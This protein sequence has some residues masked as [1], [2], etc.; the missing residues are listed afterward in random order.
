MKTPKYTISYH[1]EDDDDSAAP[2]YVP[3]PLLRSNGKNSADAHVLTRVIPPSSREI[4]PEVEFIRH[5]LAMLTYYRL[6]YQGG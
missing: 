4:C 2:E 3:L 6:K 5:L 1:D